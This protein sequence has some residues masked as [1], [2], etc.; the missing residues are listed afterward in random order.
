MMVERYA[1]EFH[2]VLK[3]DVAIGK[4]TKA[5]G[6]QWRRSGQISV[7]DST[8]NCYLDPKH[9]SP[10]MREGGVMVP[11]KRGQGTLQAH[12]DRHKKRRL[13][14]HCE[15]SRE[16]YAV[17]PNPTPIDTARMNL[18]RPEIRPPWP[19]QRTLGKEECGHPSQHA[20][21][22]Q[23]NHGSKFGEASEDDQP[24]ATCDARSA[25]GASG[26]CNDSHCAVRQ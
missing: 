7:F 15:P 2:C 23:G 19:A 18:L 10:A 21:W 3:P 9:A 8:H 4:H 6:N 13:R 14:I 26:N 16:G 24:G 5:T 20:V 17:T 22:D 11:P 25:R 1:L 12:D